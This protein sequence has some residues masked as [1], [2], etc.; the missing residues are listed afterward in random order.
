[1]SYGFETIF[2]NYCVIS[3]L[4]VYVFAMLPIV[5]RSF[6]ENAKNR[7]N[8]LISVLIIITLC[9][10][11]TIPFNENYLIPYPWSFF[12]VIFTGFWTLVTFIA[13]FFIKPSVDEETKEEISYKSK[14]LKRM[15]LHGGVSVFIIAVLFAPLFSLLVYSVPPTLMI[16]EEYIYNIIYLLFTIDPLLFMLQFFIFLMIGSFIIQVNLEIIRLNWPDKNFILKKTLMESKRKSELNSF[17]THLHL[18][19]SLC[20]GAILFLLFSPSI[21]IAAYGF[22]AMALIAIFGDMFAALIGTNFGKHKWSFLPDKSIEGTIAGFLAGFIF[23]TLFIGVI[24]GLIGGLILVI[25][26]IIFPKFTTITDNF[27]N[28]ILIIVAFLFLFQIPNVVQ[29]LLSIP[30]IGLNILTEPIYTYESTTAFIGS[31]Y[32]LVLIMMIIVAIGLII[33]FKY[34]KEEII[35]LFTGRKE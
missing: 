10:F 24:G 34:R 9:I 13:D 1:M 30:L 6:K 8:D 14:E 28:P 21:H 20:L 22:I 18:I 29:P 27:L 26:D 25:I 4:V 19:P 35:F 15:L 17:V 2:F 7:W 3:I 23:A 33:A 11:L 31:A 32:F 5:R 16:T 12:I